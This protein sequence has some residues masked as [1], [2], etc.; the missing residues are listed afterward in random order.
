[1]NQQS[2]LW[3]ARLHHIRIDSG[4]P[5]AMTAFYRRGFGL[6]EEPVG[7]GLTL[8][9]GG[10]GGEKALSRQM[11]GKANDDKNPTI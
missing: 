5:G 9:S 8:L 7:E 1:M 6:T 3:P 4:E 11:H 2:P 10:E